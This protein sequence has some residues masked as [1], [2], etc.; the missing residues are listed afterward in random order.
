[1]IKQLFLGLLLG[2]LATLFFGQQDAWVKQKIAAT[3][4]SIFQHS[5]NCTVTGTVESATLLPLT[6][7]IKNLL[8]S[9]HD[10]EKKDW[11]WSAE[12]F[13]MSFSWPSIFMGHS[14][15]TSIIMENVQ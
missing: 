14:L 11:F 9:P 2:L 13:V 15:T 7:S 1:M 6:V 8:F 4:I 5:F 12:K 3:I 10:T